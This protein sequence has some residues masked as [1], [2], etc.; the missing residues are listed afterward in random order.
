MSEIGEVK[1]VNRGSAIW[2]EVNALAL[3]MNSVIPDDGIRSDVVLSALFHMIRNGIGTFFP[4]EDRLATFDA[5]ANATRAAIE[6][7][8]AAP[9]GLN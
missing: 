5:L 7:D 4:A 9:E 6:T 3:A 8:M 2:E 1:R